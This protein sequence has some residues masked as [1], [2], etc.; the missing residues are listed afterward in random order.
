MQQLNIVNLCLAFDPSRGSAY[1]QR[2]LY[3]LACLSRCSLGGSHKKT[4]V[5]L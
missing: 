2:Q 4:A 1:R 5:D 3:S